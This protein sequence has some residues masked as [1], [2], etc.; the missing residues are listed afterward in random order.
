MVE[1]CG[2]TCKRSVIGIAGI[3]T[4]LGLSV[5]TR[6]NWA[7]PFRDARTAP[8]AL[9]LHGLISNSPQTPHWAVSIHTL[10]M[11][12][13]IRLIK[14]NH[15]IQA[16]VRSICLSQGR[17]CSSSLIDKFNDAF[18]VYL[19]LLRTVDVR[20][21]E[22]LGR[23]DPDWR[24]KHCCPACLHRVPDEPQLEHVLHWSIDGNQSTKRFKDAGGA[25]QG[26]SNFQSTYMLSEEKVNEWAHVVKKRILIPKDPKV[27]KK[28]AAAEKRRN[29][30]VQRG[31]CVQN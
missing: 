3:S 27:A 14:P 6:Y 10:A 4:Y 26:I 28:Q 25:A 15:S 23:S 2:F 13:N 18:D 17:T 11:Y 1:I 16:F 20:G 31:K 21:K 9:L 19:A 7:V 29:R 22:I 8:E 12:R 30:I 5:G 24:A